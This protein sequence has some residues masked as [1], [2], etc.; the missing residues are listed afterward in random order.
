MTALFQD[1]VNTSFGTIVG[2]TLRGGVGEYLGIPYA[3]PPIGHLRFS[4]PFDWKRPYQDGIWSADRARGFCVQPYDPY[5]RPYRWIGEEDCLYLNVWTPPRDTGAGTGR[6]PV[7]F[8]IHGGTLKTG[9]GDEYDGSQLALK[10]GVVVVTTNYRLNDLGW[11]FVAPGHANLG[12][13]DQRSAMRWV[14]SHLIV[15]CTTSAPR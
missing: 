9:S 6:L 10:H 5:V 7:L 12:L 3:E 8:F 1:M 11:A 4:P 13:K 2:R 15:S 14:R